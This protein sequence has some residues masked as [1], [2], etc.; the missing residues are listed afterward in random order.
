MIADGIVDRA[1][2]PLDADDKDELSFSGDVV[3]AFL[4]AETAQTDLL[5][6][7]ITVFFD[8]GFC[9]LEDD[10]TLLLIGLFND[11][12]LRLTIRGFYDRIVSPPNDSVP[13]DG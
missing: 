12:Q 4:L 11:R 7:G 2:L 6:L 8:I 10:F 3:A 9:A 5:T 13:K 1:S